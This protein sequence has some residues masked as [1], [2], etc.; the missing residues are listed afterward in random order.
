[1]IP[2]LLLALSLSAQA[3]TPTLPP[4]PT[5]ETPKADAAVTALALKIYQQMRAGK[6]DPA[7]LSDE[8]QKALTPEVL[9]QNKPMFDQLGDPTKLAVEKKES[10]PEGIKWTYLATFPTAQFHVVL[11]V[12][13][14][15]K[16]AGYGLQ[17]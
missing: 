15:G 2:S 13:K 6:V 4:E 5:A 3:Q 14:A 12:D 16:V 7:L 10:R 11:F 9:A 17:P 1:M 8:A